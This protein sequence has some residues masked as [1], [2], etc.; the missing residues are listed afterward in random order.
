MVRWLE[1]DHPLPFLG[2]V[3]E[4]GLTQGAV[5]I[6]MGV[7]LVV[8]GGALLRLEPL[9]RLLGLLTVA[10]MAISTVLS[11]TQWD[12]LVERLVVARRMAQGIPVRSGEIE[13]M[14]SL[15]PEGIAVALVV[16][17]GLLLLCRGRYGA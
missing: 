8:A 11:W 12:A 15:L 16:V 3:P 17:T 9:G 13:F 1:M 2:Y 5:G 4:S 10:L 6:A 14:Q 7:L